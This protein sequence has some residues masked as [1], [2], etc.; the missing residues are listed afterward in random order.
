LVEPVSTDPEE[1]F[2][3]V[4]SCGSLSLS[5]GS[6]MAS[7]GRWLGGFST[8]SVDGLTV[9]LTADPG[10][11]GTNTF[12]VVIKNPDGTPS[13]N[14]SVFIVTSMVEMDMGQDTINLSPASAP[15]TY[16]GQG[17]IPMAGHWKLQVVIRT[18]EDPTHLHSV[19]FTI[20]ASF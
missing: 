17:E 12:T 5:R 7:E 9:T 3:I 10:R 2:R 14:G 6:N 15:G 1:W 16:T 13:S 4:D 18:R 8:R 19:T 20:S 11:F